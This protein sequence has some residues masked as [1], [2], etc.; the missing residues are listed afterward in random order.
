[1]VEFFDDQTLSEMREL[2]EGSLPHLADVLIHGT[3]REA[4][5]VEKVAYTDGPV[6]V[7]CRLS[8]PSSLRDAERDTGGRVRVIQPWLVVLPLSDAA[9]ATL[10]EKDRLRIRGEGWER[11]LNIESIGGPFTNEIMRKVY[12]SEVR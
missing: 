8:T 4:G 2:S 3:T 11:I 5:G 9:T 1:M 6:G 12:C 7:P 10:K